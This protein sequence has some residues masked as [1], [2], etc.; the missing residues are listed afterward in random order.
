MIGYKDGLVFHDGLR[1]H[2]VDK[3]G[4]FR[5]PGD[6]VQGR[7]LQSR[8]RESHNRFR[9]GTSMKKEFIVALSIWFNGV[10]LSLE[11]PVNERPILVSELVGL[12]SSWLKTGFCGRIFLR[13]DEMEAMFRVFFFFCFFCTC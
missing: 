10:L 5:T 9:V 11:F 13:C 6:V 3:M 2:L 8:R 7:K 12:L 1:T 4:A